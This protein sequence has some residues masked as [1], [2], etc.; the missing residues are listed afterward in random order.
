MPKLSTPHDIVSPSSSLIERKPSAPGSYGHHRQTSIVHGNIQHSRNTS[1]VNTPSTSP[2]AP[3]VISKST[4]PDGR[5]MPEDAVGR[6][7]LLN[8]SAGLKGHSPSASIG[9]QPAM[10][11]SA[12]RRPQRVHS[13]SSRR[14]HNRS[15]SRPHHHIEARTMGENALYHLFNNFI[16][17]AEQKI[18]ECVGDPL[19]VEPRVESIMGPGVD[20]I[21]DQLISALGQVARRKPKPLID[22]LMLWRKKKSEAAN[23][24]REVLAQNRSMVDL[25]S[26]LQQAVITAERHS[27]VSIYLLCRVLMEIFAQST[28]A[29]VTPDMAI[30]LEDIIYKQLAAAD[31]DYLDESPLR[32]SN[33]VI[34]GQLL[35]AMSDMD[36]ENVSRRFVDDLEKMQLRPGQRRD[37]EGRAVLVIRGMRWLKV[38]FSAEASWDR[39]CDFMQTLARLAST[40]SGH[41]IKYEF[42]IL[43]EELLLPLAAGATSELNTPKWRTTV[44]MIKPRLLQMLIKPKHWPNVFPTLA[45]LLCASPQESFASQWLSLVMPLQARLKERSTRPASLRAVCRLVWTYL[46][47]VSDTNATTLKVL[48]DIIRLIF[49]PG[50]RSYVTTEPAVAEPLIMLI[51]IIGFK[52]QELCFRTIIFPLMNGDLFT[53]GREV[54]IVEL[55]P[56]K[57]VIGIRGFLASMTDLEKGEPPGFPVN[58]EGNQGSEPFQILLNPLS[59]RP[60][61]ESMTKSSVVKEDR[62]SRPVMVTA[63]S[64]V[65]KDAYTKFCTILGEITLFCDNAFG[66]QAVLDEKFSQAPKTPMAEAFSFSRRD[67]HQ[68]VTESRQGFYDLLHVAVQALPR[69]LSPHISFK[70]L[71]NLLCTGTAHVPKQHRRL[72]RQIAQ[73]NCP[74]VTRAAGHDRIR[75]IYIQFR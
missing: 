16:T 57:I 21:F 46:Y 40:A 39:F 67:D 5:D 14:E 55:E 8:G 59:P 33:W 7:P 38:K 23:E 58:F 69:C 27:T 4:T 50:K 13:S 74:P 10:S 19:A 61:V 70:S 45:V 43:F 73:S 42:N 68:T 64:D 72:I 52:F 22:T 29:D 1:F 44:E 34:F 20:P 75:E 11:A 12:A 71:I 48:N 41:A 18:T 51:R 3:Q 30:R 26:P 60:M 28:L 17:S 24:A 63:F 49:V 54:R 31:P 32:Q 36:F 2:L 53:S 37:L 65:T 62:L 15:Q 25:T 66:G 6:L 35:G 47:R 56:E 9:D